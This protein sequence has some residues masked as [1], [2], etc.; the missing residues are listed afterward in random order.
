MVLNF[1]NKIKESL[2]KTRAQ[3]MGSLSSLLPFGATITDDMLDEVEE[4]LYEADL[5]V[6]ASEFLVEKLR[7]RAGEIN[8]GKTDP[9]T[10][11]KESILSIIDHAKEKGTPTEKSRPYIILVVGVNGVGKT[12]TIGKLALR[13][14][15]EG[16]SVLLAA[17][18]TFRAAAVDQLEIWAKRANAEF[19]KAQE[20]ADPASVAYDAIMRA[21]ARST[22]VVIIDTAGRLHT[23]RNL[24]EELKKIRR[25]LGKS[26]ESAPHETLLVLDATTGQNALTQADVFNRD[27]NISG[28]VLTK[29]DGTA[30]GGI[31]ISIIDK[32]KIPIKLIGIGEGVDD[33]RDFD[34]ESFTEALFAGM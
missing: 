34:P 8:S 14:K 11:M 16:S 20:G 6:H 18:D 10:V 13:Y 21:K 2:K 32:L 28:I 29:L 15:N 7:D 33:L 3:L 12:T 4:A 9:Y 27:L 30:K 19:I 31:V 24:M 5:G 26:D 23:S 17:C 25:V 22:D 1:V